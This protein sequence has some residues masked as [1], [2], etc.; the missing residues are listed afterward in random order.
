MG[1]RK[2]PINWKVSNE[3]QVEKGRKLAML[4]KSM[5]QSI[6]EVWDCELSEMNN[7]KKGPRY[8]YPDSLVMFLLILKQISG[9]SYRMLEGYSMLFCDR[10][11]DYSRIQRRINKLPEELIAGL[12]REIVRAK[13]SKTIEIIADA[14]GMQINGR[15]VWREEKYGSKKRRVW[16]KL[17]LVIDSKTNMILSCE[18]FDGSENEGKHENTV[19]AVSEAISNCGKEVTKIYLD[20]SYGSNNNIAFFDY[21]GIEP[22]VRIRKDSVKKAHRKFCRGA[23]LSLR[24]KKSIEQY[25][26]K[27]FVEVKRYG[28]RSGIEGV[29]GAFKR[30]FREQLLS[31]LDVM[32]KKE[33]S[34]KVFMWNL[35]N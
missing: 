17:H 7:G 5:S 19:N 4:T 35:M 15:H 25:D 3:K 24:D 30:M 27:R 18:I 16:K 31:K 1:K 2:T 28:K 33:V 9:Q 32:I 6:S 13:T 22:I 12:N 23:K 26:W 34:A 11:P 10:V 29:I 14:T 21:L 20:G 8:L